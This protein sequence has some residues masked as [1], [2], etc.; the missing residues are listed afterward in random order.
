VEVVAPGVF[1][2]AQAWYGGGPRIVRHVMAMPGGGTELELFAT[3][4]RNDYDVAIDPFMNLFSRG[5]TND[6][7]GWNIR[8]L[9]LIQS[10]EYGYPRLFQNFA[11][12]IL[13]ALEDLGGGSGVGAL[14]LSEPTWPERYN[15]QPL[16]ADW[17]RKAIFLHRLT[18]DGPTFTQKVEEFAQISQ[19][20]D[21]D[22]DPS[23]QMFVGAWDG[24]GF[25][26]D[27]GKGYVSRITPKGWSYRAFPDLAT[28]PLPDLVT[29][30][31]SARPPNA[32][33]TAALAARSG[34][35]PVKCIIVK[36]GIVIGFDVG[37]VSLTHIPRKKGNR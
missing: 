37:V 33:E 20:T 31:S 36:P 16:M 11:T 8:F 19:V 35:V 23:G 27:P 4:T 15:N 13:P 3:G 5:N 7:G 21:L 9:H 6:G 29:L 32:A 10:A 25:K 22:V 24:A 26:G 2:A 12:E 30:L 34:N 14:F 1:A 28:A 18:P 17:G